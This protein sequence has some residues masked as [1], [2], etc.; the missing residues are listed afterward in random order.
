MYRVVQGDANQTPDAQDFIHLLNNLT[1]HS[2]KT[3]RELFHPGADLFVGRAPGRLDAMGGIADYSGSHVLEMPIA[4]A[5]FVAVQRNDERTLNIITSLVGEPHP[6]DPS[7]VAFKMALSV[8]DGPIEYEAARQFFRLHSGTHWS[9]Y[10]AG[11]FLVLMRERNV[12]FTSGANILISSRVPPGKGVS[13]SG[14]ALAR[15][16]DMPTNG[17]RSAPLGTRAD[18]EPASPNWPMA[19]MTC[20][21]AHFGC[22]HLSEAPA[23]H[24]TPRQTLSPR[25]R[26]SFPPPSSRSAGTL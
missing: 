8:F 14:F 22:T 9:A 16:L 5:T 6:D 1:T 26:R 3:A 21:F 12:S 19:A 17:A 13:S 23:W 15:A 11:V 18:M 24:R 20:V 25:S 7:H 2:L 10:V 4:E